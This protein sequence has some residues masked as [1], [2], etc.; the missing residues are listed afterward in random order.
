MWGGVTDIEER[1]AGERKF[2]ILF[3]DWTSGVTLKKEKKERE[4][5]RIV[6]L[7]SRRVSACPDTHS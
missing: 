7:V 6:V 3:L 1:E 2:P 4:K 5:N